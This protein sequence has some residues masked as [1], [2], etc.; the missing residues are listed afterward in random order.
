MK[1]SDEPSPASLRA[2]PEVDFSKMRRLSRGKYAAKARRSFAVA[3][4]E[5]DLFAHF[6]SSAA[7]NVALRALVE[8]AKTVRQTGP[9]KVARKSRSKAA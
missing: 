3:L 9:T 8:A 5:P 7:V 4:V 1:K 2:I 6:G